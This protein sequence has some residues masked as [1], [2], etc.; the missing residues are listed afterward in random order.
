VVELLDDL[1]IRFDALA[2][3]HGI[4]KIKTVG[5]AYMAVAGAP[6]RR[7]D[8]ATAAVQFA[9]AQLLEVAAWRIANGI[10]LRV[11]I[12]LAS[13][14]VVGGVI[15]RQRLLFDLWGDTVNTASR[16][17]SSGVAGRIQ[18]AAST[19]ERLGDEFVLEERRIEVKGLGEMT[20][21]LLAEG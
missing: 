1:F 4:E 2:A 3:A 6:E 5:D 10:D 20:T 18:V 15:G 11:R 9:S 7:D 21:Y 19:R 14:P 16:M 8:H 13:G 17:E 12:G